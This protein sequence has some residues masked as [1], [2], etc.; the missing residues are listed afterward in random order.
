MSLLSRRRGARPVAH[1]P[2][3]LARALPR[4]CAVLGAV[5]LRPDGECWLVA[6]PHALL[7]LERDDSEAGA[8]R[9]AAWSMLHDCVG[10][11]IGTHRLLEFYK[12]HAADMD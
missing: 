5:P 8:L 1:L 9:F 4:G 11:P 12:R 6:A 3:D 7:H 2:Q 10:E